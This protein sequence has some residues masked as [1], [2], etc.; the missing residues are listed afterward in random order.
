MLN[1]SSFDFRKGRFSGYCYDARV[2]GEIVKGEINEGPRNG[3]P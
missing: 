2:N 3:E 1:I